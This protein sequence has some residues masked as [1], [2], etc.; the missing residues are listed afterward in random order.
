MRRSPWSAAIRGGCAVMACAALSATSHARS[1]VSGHPA[2][3]PQAA[4]RAADQAEHITVI[5]KRPA[6]QPAPLPG[7]ATVPDASTGP[8]RIALPFGSLEIGGGAGDGRHDAQTGA[9]ISPFGG[10][11]THAGPIAGGPAPLHEN[12]V[13]QP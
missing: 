3:A 12:K 10:A 11:Y 7:D 6:L 4:P 1:A 8:M 13:G 5:G 2:A 9:L